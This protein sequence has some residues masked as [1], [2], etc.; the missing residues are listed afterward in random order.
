MTFCCLG[1]LLGSG[2]DHGCQMAIARYLDRMCWALGSGLLDYG[3]A[4]LR[5]KIWS[6][7]F[8]GLR[9]HTLH[10]GAIQGKEGVKFCHLATLQ[11]TSRARAK[12][13]PSLTHVSKGTCGE[14]LAW[15][16]LMEMIWWGRRGGRMLRGSKKTKSE[17][18]SKRNNKI[19]IKQDI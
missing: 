2:G 14:E 19:I 7:P 6:L 18:K 12:L 15:S 16:C 3:S 17:K 1:R 4:T 8:L 11:G 5:C 13:S 10:P 9:P